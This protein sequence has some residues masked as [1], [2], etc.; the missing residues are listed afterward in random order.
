MIVYRCECGSEFIVRDNTQRYF[1]EKSAWK[2]IHHKVN[3][4]H[5]Y[6]RI[7]MKKKDLKD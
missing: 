1:D 7:T 2:K 4:G 5:G 3:Y 6:R